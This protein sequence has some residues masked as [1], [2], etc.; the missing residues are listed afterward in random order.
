MELAKTIALSAAGGMVFGLVGCG[1][2]AAP[3]AD[4]PTADTTAAAD[5][6]VAAG[7]AATKACCKGQNECAKKGNCKVDGVN[8]C[9]GQNECA[10]KGGCHAPDCTP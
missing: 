2:S 6:A 9:K 5:T 3:A 7:E 10:K 8:E 4:Q 1:G